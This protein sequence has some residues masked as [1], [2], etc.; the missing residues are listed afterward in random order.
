MA[1]QKKRI[2]G[3]GKN[4]FQQSYFVTQANLIGRSSGRALTGAQ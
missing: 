2:T 3:Y 1:D 4:G